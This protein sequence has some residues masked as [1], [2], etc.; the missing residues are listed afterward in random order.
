MS[1]SFV[2][3]VFINKF[4]DVKIEFDNLIL[5]LEY[6]LTLE[7][8]P[9]KHKTILGGE[10]SIFDETFK[11][12][13]L[14]AVNLAN[15]HIMDY[16]ENGFLKTVEY[17]EKHEICYFGAGTKENNYNNPAIIEING[18]RVALLGYSC[19]ST[20]AIF[21]AENF[22]GSA[23]LDVELILNDINKCKKKSDIIVL[24]LHWGNEYVHYPNPLD[25]DKAHKFIDAGVELIIGH[26]A[27]VVQSFEIYKGKYIFYG[28]GNF[29]F[30]ERHG[31][32]NYDGKKFL[33]H[34]YRKQYRENKQALIVEMNVDCSINYNTAITNGDII[35]NRYFIIPKWIPKTI[36]QY[37]LYLKFWRKKRIFQMYFRNPKIP[38]IKQ[39]MY[40]LGFKIN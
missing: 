29:L 17:L 1:L 34:F 9:A 37:R 7:G 5:N 30:S 3:D 24:N 6:P 15:N 4:V 25:V 10:E 31:V 12:S 16:G 8:E 35:E 14:L 13:K 28:L 22:N 26:H 21:G 20:N 18:K 2:G 39:I 19:P 23:L 33:K 36:G 27:H 11:N 32:A 38:T 40:V